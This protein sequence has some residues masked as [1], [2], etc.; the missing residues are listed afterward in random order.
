MIQLVW[1]LWRQ[2]SNTA[3]S[4]FYPFISPLV[5]SYSEKAYLELGKTN[6]AF[7]HSYTHERKFKLDP[8]IFHDPPT[9]DLDQTH[10]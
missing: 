2:G 5:F 4:L 1:K 9:L 6:S 8:A 10:I 7:I 3:F